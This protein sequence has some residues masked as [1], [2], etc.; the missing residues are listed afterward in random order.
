MMITQKSYISGGLCVAK[1][2]EDNVG[3]GPNIS[4]ANHRPKFGYVQ[5]NVIPMYIA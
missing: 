3:T 2:N 1:W 4:N 5:Y